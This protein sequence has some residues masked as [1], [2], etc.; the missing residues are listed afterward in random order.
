MQITRRRVGV[1]IAAAIFAW[2]I[3]YIGYNAYMSA[4]WYSTIIT[5]T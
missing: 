5:L 2:S 1:W 4:K 3:I